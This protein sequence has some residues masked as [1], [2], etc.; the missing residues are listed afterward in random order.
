M[1]KL[2]AILL[3][4]AFLL[5]TPSPIQAEGPYPGCEP[6][7]VGPNSPT[8][9]YKC[10]V[11][12]VGT[13]SWYSGSGVARNDCIYPWTN[14]QTISIRSLDTGITIVVTPV[15][16]CDCYTGT[17]K[18]RIVDRSLAQVRALGL[19]PN[20]GLF[21]VEVLPVD[22]GISTPSTDTP[23]AT[24]PNTATSRGSVWLALFLL[25]FVVGL[26]LAWRPRD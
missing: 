20:R 12:G 26:W 8:G 16:F 3:S 19:D 14:C 1:K 17:S 7:P 10:I 2:I 6:Y 15:T 25:A 18:E 11:Y 13:A 21:P 5:A 22:Q 24:I 4:M 9:I 23:P